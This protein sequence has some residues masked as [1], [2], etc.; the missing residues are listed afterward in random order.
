MTVAGV[1]AADTHEL[2]GVRTLARTAR[3]VAY[4]PATTTTAAP[5]A[6]VR[7]LTRDLRPL[8]SAAAPTAIVRRLTGDLRSWLT[9]DPRFR[10]TGDLRSWLSAAATDDSVNSCRC[11]EM[12]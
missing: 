9:G 6:I 5:T 7:R 1:S 11:G 4:P 8:L 3:T 12:P 2:G 10:L